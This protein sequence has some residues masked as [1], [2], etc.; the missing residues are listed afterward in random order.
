MTPVDVATKV[1]PVKWGNE[2]SL[3]ASPLLPVICVVHKQLWARQKES[4]GGG[5]GKAGILRNGRADV[6]PT[7][8][9]G[10]Q[11]CGCFFQCRNRVSKAG[12]TLE[13]CQVVP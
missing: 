8:A 9:E 13:E 5:E 7:R 10:Q 11:E 4:R 6:G 12:W 1:S 3:Q 2:A